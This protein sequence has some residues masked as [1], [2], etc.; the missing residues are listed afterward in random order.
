MEW[1]MMHPLVRDEHLGYIPSFLKL[2][3][4]RPAKEQFQERYWPG[5]H[6]FTGFKMDPKT[7]EL[8]Y[9]GDPAYKPLASTML[10]DEKVLVYNHAWVA[11]VQKDGSYEIARMD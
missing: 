8:R 1:E 10:R 4:E 9:P 7:Y 3:D 2:E 6:P 11:I 5:W